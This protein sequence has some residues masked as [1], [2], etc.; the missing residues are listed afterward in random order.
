MTSQILKLR[1]VIPEYFTEAT[2]FLVD[3]TEERVYFEHDGE[4]QARI[5]RDNERVVFEFKYGEDW[6]LCDWATFEE[7]NERNEAAIF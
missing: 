3:E 2:D 7:V 4:M 1:Y 6:H 5:D